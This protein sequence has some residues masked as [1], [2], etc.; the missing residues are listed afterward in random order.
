VWLCAGAFAVVVGVLQYA[1]GAYTSE[2]SGYPDEP[3]HYVTGLMFDQYVRA[4]FPNP[5]RYAERYYVRY[6]QVA[7]GHWP[8]LFYVA[9]SLWTLLSRPSRV[10]VLVFQAGLAVGL[11]LLLRWHL[12]RS[13]GEPLAVAFSL[14]FL[15][16]PIV[17]EHVGMV[18]AEILLT[19]LMYGASIM[20]ALY[21]ESPRLWRSIAF[22]VLATAAILTK[23]NAWA[24]A[25]VPLL[26]VLLLRRWSAL[27]SASFY[28]GALPVI[29]VGVPWQ[30]T[31]THMAAQGWDAPAPSVSLGVQAFLAFASL[32]W[33]MVGGAIVLAAAVG[34]WGTLIAPW[35]RGAVSPMWA[36]MGSLIISVWIFHCIVPAGIEPR[37]LMLALPALIAFAAAG[38]AMIADAWPAR[39]SPRWLRAAVVGVVMLAFGLWTFE[40]PAKRSFGFRDAATAIYGSRWAPDDS[41]MLI[42]SS[43]N[44]EGLFISEYAMLQPTP[45]LFIVR[46]SKLL[47]EMDWGGA[48]YRPLYSTPDSVREVL[49]TLPVGIVI[50]DERDAPHR[51]HQVLLTDVLRKDATEW[52]RVGSFGDLGDS[53]PA[54]IVYRRTGPIHPVQ[55]L[56]VNTERM[57]GR[58]VVG[59]P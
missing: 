51:L 52:S 18:M 44:G 31:T 38:C 11:A 16:A 54:V 40:I 12:S 4:R 5:V 26:S 59:R 45:R 32:W 17:Q 23:G 49:D 57:L 21:L 42:T 1:S 14:I 33:D 24:L 39:K 48:S 20:F 22:G 15:A 30:L 35:P 50:L 29:L 56:E 28:L 53:R 13:L 58:N 55:E 25:P 27:R 9:Q 43:G 8:P 19:V 41:A 36:S 46:G 3:A 2:L 7:I 34:V 47:A 10:S 37:K 6:P